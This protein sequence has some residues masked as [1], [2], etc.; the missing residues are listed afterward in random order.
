MYD[1]MRLLPL[2]V[3]IFRVPVAVENTYDHICMSILVARVQ[4]HSEFRAQ[5]RGPTWVSAKSSSSSG[6]V[7]G[8]GF[9]AGFGACFGDPI[10]GHSIP[11]FGWELQASPRNIP[12]VVAEAYEFM[13]AGSI[14]VF[15]KRNEA[16]IRW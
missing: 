13:Y 16:L 11:S 12:W 1:M 6:A 10:W 2:P 7:L 8:P 5:K 3:K 15:L 4:K 14:S 9:G